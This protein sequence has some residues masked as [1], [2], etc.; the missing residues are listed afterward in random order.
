M[1]CPVGSDVRQERHRRRATESPFQH[2]R[3]RIWRKPYLLNALQKIRRRCLSAIRIDLVYG[4]AAAPGDGLIH[5][6][7]HHQAAVQ[8]AV[9]DDVPVVERASRMMMDL[10]DPYR[11]GIDDVVAR[12]DM[13]VVAP[14]PRIHDI[15][16]VSESD[17]VVPF[18]GENLV[19]A[20]VRR[21]LVIAATH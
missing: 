5:G 8:R 14:E 15:V 1:D 20:V 9:I 19:V 13:N 12:P 2:H 10:T 7:L 6:R 21:D 18:L 16:A 11:F 4:K 17:R 3:V